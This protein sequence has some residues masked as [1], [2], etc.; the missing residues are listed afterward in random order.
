VQRLREHETQTTR[1][2]A[3]H[4]TGGDER[5]AADEGGRMIEVGQRQT[6]SLV[7]RELIEEERA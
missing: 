2:E 3:G 1:E 5:H 7:N 4:D 6:G